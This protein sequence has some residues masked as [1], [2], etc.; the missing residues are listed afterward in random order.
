VQL[1]ASDGVCL[2]VALEDIK[3]QKPAFFKA[4]FSAP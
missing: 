1:R 2:S 4:K 3:K